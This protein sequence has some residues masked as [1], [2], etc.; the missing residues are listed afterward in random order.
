[1]YS[2][3]QKLNH[4]NFANPSYDPDFNYK[5]TQVQQAMNTAV[6][7]FHGF[8]SEEV[9]DSRLENNRVR[10]LDI[11]FFIEDNSISISEPKQR[12]SGI[13]QGP[14]L[15]RQKVLGPDAKTFLNPFDFHVGEFIVICARK[16][17]LATCDPFTRNFYEKIGSAQ[18]ENLNI[19]ADNYER[20]VLK[21]FEPK[22]YYGLNSSVLNGRVPLQKKF[23]END[24]KVLKFW[25][26]SE[27]EPFVVHY[28][29]ADDTI[30]VVEVKVVN[31]GKNPFP[32]LM[33][34]Q[35]MPNHYKVTMPGF[36][37]TDNYLTY[38][39]F[40]PNCSIEFLGRVFKIHN[41]DLFTKKFYEEVNGQ[42]FAIY[43]GDQTECDPRPEMIIPPH[44]GFGNEEDSLQNVLKLIPKP[45]KKDFYNLMNNTGLLKLNGVLMTDKKNNSHRFSK[46]TIRYNILLR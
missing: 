21:S 19:D 16:I 23:L 11:N 2:T 40:K 28:Y 46:Q 26:E 17:F 37:K 25:V 14:F 12:N 1:M 44:N 43:T 39:D 3:T 27:G 18:S 34:R 7:N 32:L 29:L 5:R 13:L 8:F 4:I 22:P 38:E 30:E 35:R 9:T 24:R 15:K 31:S 6:L 42:S 45:P 20:I 36:S 33:K 41:C 10:H